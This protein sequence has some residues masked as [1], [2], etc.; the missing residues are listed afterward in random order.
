MANH[1]SYR[2][3][4]ACQG[5]SGGRRRTGARELQASPAAAT[6]VARYLIPTLF[7]LCRAG[8][9]LTLEE[10]AAI[11]DDPTRIRRH[12]AQLKHFNLICKDAGRYFPTEMAK[13]FVNGNAM[14]PD[15]VWTLD[16]RVVNAPVQI[17]PTKYQFAWEIAGAGFNPPPQR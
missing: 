6:G 4:S 11:S 13:N 9:G 2:L 8:K 7:E 12:F 5:W 15:A 1:L 10:I 16:G 3:A 17:T 14:V